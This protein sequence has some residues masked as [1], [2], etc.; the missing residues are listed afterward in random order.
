MLDRTLYSGNNNCNH[1]NNR[2]CRNHRK[3][4]NM[5]TVKRDLLSSKL[6]DALNLS[7]D[8]IGRY[9]KLGLIPFEKTPGGHR[10]YNLSEV[11]L[12]LSSMESSGISGLVLPGRG[13]VNPLALGPK[14]NPSA[15]AK[16]SMSIRAVR[17]AP[18]K[19]EGA[20]HKRGALD[21]L[22]ASARRVLVSQ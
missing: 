9:A 8:T 11:R 22:L 3:G 2:K 7:T 10:R 4:A 19:D 21:E 5:S 18:M 15:A 13:S 12:A 1:R 14:T 20:E 16:L 6:A 17:T